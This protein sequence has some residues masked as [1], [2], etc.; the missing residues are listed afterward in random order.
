MAGQDDLV[1]KIK[2]DIRAL[3]A[4]LKQAAKEADIAGKAMQNSVGAR[5]TRIQDSLARGA[6]AA[7]TALLGIGA[8]SA[9]AG[10]ALA[11]L[12]NRAFEVADELSN[13]SSKTGVT[14]EE[15]QR[16][17]YV[18]DQAGV[19]A[20]SMAV[21]FAYFSRM[22]GQ[23]AAGNKTAVQGFDALGISVVGV[24]GKLRSVDEVLLEVLRRLAEYP[25][26]AT[27]AAAAAGVFGAKA[28]ASMALLATGA[29]DL[30]EVR[31]AAE[32]LGLVIGADLVNAGDSA[33][34]ALARLKAVI[35]AGLNKAL[36][37]AAPEVENFINE[38][39]ADPAAMQE[40][41]AQFVE[42]AKK[43]AEVG[44][45]V[46]RAIGWVHD[47]AAGLGIVAAKLAGAEEWPYE[48]RIEELGAAIK[49][50]ELQIKGLDLLG[51][52]G[53]EEKQAEIARYKAEL[54]AL[55]Q[56]QMEFFNVS[57]QKGSSAAPTKAPPKSGPPP[58]LVDP[59]EAERLK[60]LQDAAQREV[61]LQR[62]KNEGLIQ[63]AREYV[64]T[65]A[66]LEEMRFETR[67]AALEAINAMEFGGTEAKNALLEKM[68][69]THADRIAGIQA[70][71]DA[72]ARDIM[73][74]KME[75]E[76]A[77]QA[78]HEERLSA[79]EAATMDSQT[80]ML[81]AEQ[82]A[83][84]QRL[85][86]LAEF[87][88]AELEAIGGYNGA[89]EELIQQHEDNVFQIR[90][91]G[92]ESGLDLL[93]YIKDDENRKIADT[94]MKG[95]Q[96]ASTYSKKA[97]E[98][99]KVAGIAN[100]IVNTAQGVTEALKLPFPLSLAAA[101]SVAAA[102]FA[103]IQAIRNTKFGGG[104]ASGST[105]GAANPNNTTQPGGGGP[106]I[107]LTLSGSN[108]SQD[109]VRGLIESINEALAD[110]ATLRR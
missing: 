103:Q 101:A 75:A 95:L 62:E 109:Q 8:A 31:A 30:D 44:G 42:V 51:F 15:L 56:A 48:K 110:G 19:S 108:F 5:V 89:K 77:Y 80:R 35:S 34:D 60:R 40:R 93:A 106:Q 24:D 53:I 87:S 37:Q 36:L 28:G 81:I 76:A 43:I 18:G 50:T 73:E 7:G 65:E 14:I 12:L 92:L 88:D 91:Q 29:G 84:S 3:Q 96:V 105:A 22:V 102:G 66:G 1:V 70:Q 68:A 78:A 82:D 52:E 64:A 46:M 86:M 94:A 45:A 55:T 32:S 63:Q 83:F 25:D 33:G 38:L 57:R 79:L 59:I 61:E 104:G 6:R 21:S 20:E 11:A 107:A 90:K 100:A 72:A 16:L 99:N 9:V 74:K 2:A 10:G 26:A 13:L 69:A 85:A 71:A 98:I 47:F 27:R 49:N 4:G 17:R 58:E 41:I 67:R 97:F 23:A 39:L 54:Q